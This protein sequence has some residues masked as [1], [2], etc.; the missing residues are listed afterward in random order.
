M[1]AGIRKNSSV[2]III[3][4]AK[5]SPLDKVAGLTLG[6]DDYITKP[7]LPLELTARVKALFRRAELSSGDNREQGEMAY[8]CGN[9]EAEASGE[10]GLRGKRTNLRHADGIRFSALPFQTERRGRI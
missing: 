5:D 7:F 8:Q 10:N 9:Y 3:V 4:S 2:P 6:S 1:C